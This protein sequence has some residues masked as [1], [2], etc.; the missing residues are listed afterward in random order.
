VGTPVVFDVPDWVWLHAASTEIPT[1]TTRHR[2]VRLRATA[3]SVH[4]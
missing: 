4:I 1:T 2:F 3:V